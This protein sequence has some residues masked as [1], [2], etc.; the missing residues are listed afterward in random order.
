MNFEQQYQVEQLVNQ[1]ITKKQ[2][3]LKVI[4]MSIKNLGQYKL[5]SMFG[6]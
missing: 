5:K 4:T 2:N 6:R 1:I 3:F